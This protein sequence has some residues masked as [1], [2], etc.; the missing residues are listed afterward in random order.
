MRR[1]TSFIHVTLDGC[2]ADQNG[3]MNWAHEGSGDAEWQAF[4]AANARSGE[5]LLFGRTTYQMMLR[6]WP[7]PQATKDNPAV[8]ERMN[9]LPKVVFSRTLEAATWNNTKLVKHGL[10]DE[11]RRLKAQPGAHMAT[12]G[13]GSIV[14][15]L[16]Q[17][18]LVDELQIVVNP[19]VIG[20]GARLFGDVESRLD[21]QLT[22]TRRF[23]NGK[24]L[25]SYAPAT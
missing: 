18:G 23:D 22:H 6:Y 10:A 11:V 21:L 5:M 3:D 25:L 15:Q 8:A 17:A 16:V 1:L 20:R 4:V 7:T 9:A 24:V 13:S 2:Y 12:L 19:I 14:S